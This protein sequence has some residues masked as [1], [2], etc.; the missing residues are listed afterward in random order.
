MA[1]LLLGVDIGT[2]GC[3]IGF[4]SPDGA[5]G[6]CFT[7]SY[8][9]YRP[10]ENWAEQDPEDWWAAFVDATRQAL[11][12]VP[13][14][15]EDILAIGCGG[16]TNGHVLVDARGHTMGRSIIWQD[17]RAMAEAEE[18]KARM[19]SVDMV[20]FLGTRLPIDATTLPPR[21]LWL[22]RNE[23]EKVAKAGAVL[24][25]K[26]FINYRLTGVLAT[27]YA[28]CK[29]LIDLK[30]NEFH[31]EYFDLLGLERRLI[32]EALPPYRTIG[33]ITTE[34][35]AQT[36]LLAGTPVVAGT[37]DAWCNILGSGVVSNGLVSDVAGSSEV[38]TVFSDSGPDTDRLNVIPSFD[39]Y[40]LNGPTQAGGD[41]LRWL[42]ENV[43]FNLTKEEESA[44]YD[45]LSDL[46]SLSQ[47]GANRLIFLPYLAGER[48]P[49]WDSDARGVLLGINKSHTLADVSR[50]V[51]E[52]VAF[53]IR[54]VLETAKGIGGPET[55]QIRVSGNGAR[56][57][58]WNKI[59][60]DVTGLPVMVPSVLETGCLGAAMLAGIGNGVYSGYEDAASKT[61]LAGEEYEPDMEAHRTYDR[62]FGIYASIYPQLK[63]IFKA[64]AGI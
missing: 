9:T 25:P 61:V 46:A 2:G 23:P 7:S 30:S 55:R 31:K 40:L 1:R 38:I 35:A 59:K 34:A 19:A 48:A 37:I 18:V 14:A 26:D 22:Q 49:L 45:I 10:H 36:G 43:L 32:P 33:R 39:G 29:T 56:S 60:A 8:Q 17:R 64:L 24:Q 50:S 15:R 28:S 42:A 47:A 44:K 21:L 53:S 62:A 51:F 52:G 13:S 3:R 58:L 27:D 20:R 54:H 11:T 41:S 16:Q 12:T 63:T 4:F 57:R 6:G 5:L